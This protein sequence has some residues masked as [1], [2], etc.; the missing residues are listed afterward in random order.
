MRKPGYRSE[1]AAAV[2]E[3]V[4]GML[5]LGLVDKKT[6]HE[7]DVRCLTAAENRALTGSRAVEAR[8]AKRT[9]TPAA[10]PLKPV[11]EHRNIPG[12]ARVLPRED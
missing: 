5:R 10:T 6:M 7:S 11:R 2:H 8:A 1:V 4:R 9:I 12:Q 3:G